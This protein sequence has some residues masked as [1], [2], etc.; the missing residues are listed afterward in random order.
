MIFFHIASILTRLFNFSFHALEHRNMPYED[1]LKLVARN[2]D[3]H[4][5]KLGGEK[6]D[7]AAAPVKMPLAS[8]ALQVEEIDPKLS[9]MLINLA[10]GKNLKLDDLDLVIDFLKKKR[11]KLTGLE[12]PGQ[13]IAT[14]YQQKECKPAT[15]D[16][17][18]VQPPKEN[19]GK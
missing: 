6:T 14:T 16:P 17:S 2:F 11:E 10:E 19:T 13:P 12:N 1:A 8:K 7:A 5:L 4:L 15:T 3:A 18:P 9:L